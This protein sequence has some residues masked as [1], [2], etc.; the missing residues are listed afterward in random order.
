MTEMQMTWEQQEV[1]RLLKKAPGTKYQDASD[2]EQK[3]IRDWVR[4]LLHSTVVTV[5]FTKSDGSLRVMNCTLDLERMP[6]Q[7][8]KGMG[9]DGLPR[10]PRTSDDE[11]QVAFDV[12]L[13]QWRSFRYDRLKNVTA[14]ISFNK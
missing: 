7:N 2:T 13:Q 6:K 9:I 3:I 12:D 4:S 8:S 11:V 1:F 14:S 5:E 10:S